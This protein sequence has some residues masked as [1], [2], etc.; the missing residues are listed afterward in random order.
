V[1]KAVA[2]SWEKIQAIPVRGGPSQWAEDLD[3]VEGTLRLDLGGAEATASL[4]SRPCDLLTCG[5]H[6]RRAGPRAYPGGTALRR[7]PE[8]RAAG[9]RLGWSLLLA[10]AAADTAVPDAA[11]LRIIKDAVDHGV[12]RRLPRVQRFFGAALP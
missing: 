5:P 6:L 8:W 4:G 11:L 1:L 3:F 12:R 7:G 2:D 9:R 10:R